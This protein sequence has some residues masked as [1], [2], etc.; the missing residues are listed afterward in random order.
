MLA[1]TYDGGE[2]DPENRGLTETSQE[3]VL[4]SLVLAE[5]G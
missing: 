1:I 2:K 3:E 5:R 4:C